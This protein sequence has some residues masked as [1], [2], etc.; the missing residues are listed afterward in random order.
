[1]AEEK[2]PVVLEEAALAQAAKRPYV[3]PAIAEEEA[4]E[5]CATLSCTLKN[6]SPPPKGCRGG[7]QKSL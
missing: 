6:S 4:Y 5:T 2:M 7:Q 3:V 1:M